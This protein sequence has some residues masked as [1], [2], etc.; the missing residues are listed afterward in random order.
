MGWSTG[1]RE[2]NIV[3]PCSLAHFQMR[4][5]GD[6]YVALHIFPTATGFAFLCVLRLSP[7][8]EGVAEPD[9]RAELELATIYSINLWNAAPLKDRP[10]RLL[11]RRT[12]PASLEKGLT[13]VLFRDQFLLLCLC[14]PFL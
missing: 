2:F 5:Y 10:A 11:T 3:W 8:T 6:Q 7:H 9:H 12:V 13:P 4:R 14:I 1:P